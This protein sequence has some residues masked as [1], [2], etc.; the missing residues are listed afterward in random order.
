MM[1]LESGVGNYIWSEGVKYS[2]FAGNNYLGLANHPKL[3]EAA[4]EGIKKFGINFSASRQTTGTSQIHLELEK[5][6]ARFKHR[7]DAAIFASGY[8]GNKIIIHI[9]AKTESLKRV[10]LRLSPNGGCSALCASICC[11]SKGQ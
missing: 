11:A 8:M 7:D 2:C 6:L 1:I 9:D 4:I 5:L 3:V 10:S